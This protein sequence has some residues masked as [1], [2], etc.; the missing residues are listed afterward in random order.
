[1]TFA[2]RCE[3]GTYEISQPQTFTIPEEGAAIEIKL[4]ATPLVDV[5]TAKDS[6]GNPK[7]ILPALWISCDYEIGRLQEE[8][9]K[10]VV[11]QP[12]KD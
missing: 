11:V 4:A 12:Q 1:M 10:P 3:Q 8:V 7:P 5:Q 6:R 9:S 2:L